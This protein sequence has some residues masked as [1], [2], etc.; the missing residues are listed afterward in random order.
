MRRHLLL[1]FLIIG[2]SFS[3]GCPPK[4]VGDEDAGAATDGS[5]DGTDDISPDAS[6][7]EPQCVGVEPGST[8]YKECG[9]DG[10]GGSC[11]TCNEGL[12]CSPTGL[13]VEQEDPCQG[14]PSVGKCE[15]NTLIECKNGQR[16]ETDCKLLD[17]VCDWENNTETNTAGYACVDKSCEPQCKDKECGNDGCGGECGECP[18]HLSCNA[19]GMCECM[20]NCEGKQ[21]G[22][23]GCGGKCGQCQYWNEACLRGECV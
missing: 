21:C 4:D 17:K 19:S 9:A 15:D 14:I 12:T 16:L 13:C 20:P 7:C 1:S 10:C 22:D 5:T 2:L 18:D 23:D 3:Y 6:S 8:Y 11:G